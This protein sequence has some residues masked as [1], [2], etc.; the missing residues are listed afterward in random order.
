MLIDFN[1][2]ISYRK[3]LEISKLDSR[4]LSEIISDQ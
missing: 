1:V 2:A 4:A 3:P